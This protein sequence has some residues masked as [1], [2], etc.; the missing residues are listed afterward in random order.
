LISITVFVVFNVKN[1]Y[2]LGLA[3]RPP[4]RGP[5][6]TGGPWTTD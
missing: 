6:I 2:I 5:Q 4:G 1:T 3:R